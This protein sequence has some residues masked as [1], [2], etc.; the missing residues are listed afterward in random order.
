[1][2]TTMW[3]GAV[4]VLTPSLLFGLA[5]LLAGGSGDATP[6]RDPRCESA[7][8]AAVT[9]I[10]DAVGQPDWH[11]TRR[12]ERGVGVL[13]AARSHCAYGWVEHGLADYAELDR[14]LAR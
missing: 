8:R 3:Q 4:L 6:A 9:R 5:L 1:M 14:M 2:A 11:S 13:V 10:R 7:D 12:L